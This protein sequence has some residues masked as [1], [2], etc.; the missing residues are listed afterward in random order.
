MIKLDKF[1]VKAV[2]PEYDGDQPVVVLTSESGDEI[3]IHPFECKDVVSA[4]TKAAC[5]AAVSERE[6]TS[7]EFGHFK[8]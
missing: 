7:E 5:E 1:V 8:K 4:L 6:W 2:P 3:V